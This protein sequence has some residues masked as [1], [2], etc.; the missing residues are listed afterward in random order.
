MTLL[1]LIACLLA[2][3]LA[4]G[5]TW[6]PQPIPAPAIQ[7]EWET[8]AARLQRHRSVQGPYAWDIPRC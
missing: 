8:P 5:D 1:I 3:A 2:F 6:Q 4:F 7:P